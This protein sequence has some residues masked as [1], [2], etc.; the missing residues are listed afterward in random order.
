VLGVNAHDAVIDTARVA[1]GA[2][3]PFMLSSAVVPAATAADAGPFDEELPG[4]EDL[5]WLARVARIAPVARLE[6]VVGA[7]RIHGSSTTAGQFL[8]QRQASRFV[9]ARLHGGAASWEEYRTRSVPA[10]VRRQD[11]VAWHYRACGIALGERSWGR[12]AR[13]AATALTLD[14]RGSVKR[15]LAHR[16]R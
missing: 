7:Y 9:A 4:S 11:R 16:G 5:D 10:D 6:R 1:A 15:A 2:L 3:M 12:A 14:P 8:E 13:H